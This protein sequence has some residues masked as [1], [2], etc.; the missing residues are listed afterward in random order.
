MAPGRAPKRIGLAIVGAGRIGLIR[1]EIAAKNASVGWIGVA[2]TRADR[3]KEVAA[4]VGAEFVSTDFHELLRRPEVTAA[5]IATDEHLHVE[6][7]LAAVERGVSLLI[8][9]PLATD[10]AQSARV[11][12]AIT[13]A[14]LDAVVGY[15]QRFRR[16][17]LGA[18]EKVRSGALGDVTL[19]TS[20]A[21]MNRLAALDNYK[22]T[23]DPATISPMVIS[24]THALD[25]VMWMMEAKKQVEVY[26][27]S[28]DKALGPQ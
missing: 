23:N 28:I 14:K 16:K 26:A 20:R 7:I 4:R 15:T 27:R 17:W 19:V 1:G 18:K 9:K 6:P 5:V 12:E 22:R 21:F 2:E 8:E 24:G 11:L 13:D 3:G 10:L 25:V